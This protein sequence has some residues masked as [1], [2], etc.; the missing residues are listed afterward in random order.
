[1]DYTKYTAMKKLL[2]VSVL[3]AIAVGKLFAQARSELTLVAAYELVEETYPLLK[4]VPL[5]EA[6]YRAKVSQLK[7]ERN[8]TVQWKADISIQSERPSL[9][10]NEQVPLQIDLP[11]Y[12]AASYLEI[13]YQLYDGGLNRAQREQEEAQQ[14]VGLQS[15]ETERYT[16]RE[17]VNRLFIGYSLNQKQAVMLQ[18]TLTDL[19]ARRKA[20]EAGLRFG[21]VLASE[22]AQLRVRELEIEAQRSDLHYANQGLLTTLSDLTGV[23]LT[24][25]AKLVLPQLPEPDRVPPLSRPEQ[26]L[27]Q[28]KK[29]A[30]L[31]NEALISAARRPKIGA[32]AQGGV[33][34]PNP[35]NFFNNGM[36]PYG[37]AG[38]NFQWSLVHWKK[39]Q[40]EREELSLQ[41]QQIANQEETYV[42]NAN[43]KTGEYL[44]SVE[45]LTN[46][47]ENDREIVALQTDV[48]QQLAVQL[49]GG[50]VTTTDYLTQANA[51]LRA[52]QQLELHQMQ[53][54]Q[55]QLEFLTDRGV[56]D[57]ATN[58]AQPDST[59]E[60]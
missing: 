24:S 15:L 52:R 42:F 12:S 3:W 49:E 17:R 58:P 23:T 44:A 25:Q 10:N 30:L 43:T 28:R 8:P 38:I 34:Y 1:M 5:T 36:A 31:A 16:L 57:L 19:Q 37:I 22:V 35:L 32:F 41:A 56:T 2:L 29:Q 27:F 54:V 4:N 47:I 55:A 7:A 53:L 13:N 20:L 40:H 33:G 18:T 6:A 46:Q 51:E 14:R 21:T 60:N 59:R 26:V 9:D 39:Q 45:R 50:V 48:L 11:L